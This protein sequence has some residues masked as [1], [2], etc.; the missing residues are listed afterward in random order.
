VIV[1]V[2][3]VLYKD[4]YPEYRGWAIASLFI[5]VVWGV[6]AIRSSIKVERAN[7]TK[8][9][10]NAEKYS[11]K[12]KMYVVSAVASCIVLFI[13]FGFPLSL[14]LAVQGSMARFQNARH[15]FG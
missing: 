14:S 7:R 8:N 11:R 12:T 3:E 6:F 5:C 13:I 9:Y 4:H 1:N 10:P 15:F 2:P